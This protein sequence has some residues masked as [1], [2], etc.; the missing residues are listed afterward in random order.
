MKTIHK[1][2]YRKKDFR[3]LEDNSERR[4]SACVCVKKYRGSL[5]KIK[6]KKQTLQGAL[7]AN[8]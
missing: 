6:L 3:Y 2:L 1:P 7:Q 8:T 5:M 4:E